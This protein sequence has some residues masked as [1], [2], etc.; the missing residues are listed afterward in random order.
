MLSVELSESKAYLYTLAKRWEDSARKEQRDHFPYQQLLDEI[1]F[2]G[3]LR[4][5]DYRQFREEGEFPDRLKNWIENVA[6][7]RQ[8]KALFHLLRSLLFVDHSQMRA[9]YRD[10]YRRIIVPW[11]FHD[12]V[13]PDYL[14]SRDYEVNVQSELRKYRFFS[15]TESFSFPEFVQENSLGG[16][17][18]GVTL[19]EDKDKVRF[20]VPTDKSKAL[21]LIV[22]EDFVGTGKQAGGVLT[23]LTHHVPDHWRILFVPLIVL[24]RGLRALSAKL[25][26]TKIEMEPALV[27]PNTSC[28]LEEPAR[29]E[30]G[31]FKRIRTL[32]KRTSK[33]VLEPLEHGD[34][35]PRDPFGYGGS[36]ALLVTSH[37]TPNNSVPV[38][39][40]RAPEWSPLFRRIYHSEDGL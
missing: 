8:R 30:P 19:G 10:A 12:K 25:R 15:I 3:D 17:T 40:H 31:E 18:K 2:H 37:N 4:Y 11:I 16:L 35:P 36:G 24:K 23:E 27:V 29:N 6:E 14:L 38:I 5:V 21:G 32:L 39:H 7:D 13:S 1:L 28:L 9:L 34:D 20:L 22:F 26:R 33:R